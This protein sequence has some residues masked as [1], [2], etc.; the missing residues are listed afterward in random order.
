MPGP[1]ADPRTRNAIE[2]K[3]AE[4]HRGW[5]LGVLS[6]LALLFLILAFRSAWLC[7]DAY[8]TFRTIDNFLGGYGLRWNVAERVQ[9]FSHPLWMLLLSAISFITG[10]IYFTALGLSLALSAGAIAVFLLYIAP[11]FRAAGLGLVIFCASKAFID[12]STS[13]LENPLTHFLLALHFA[14]LL[15]M[16]AGSRSLLLLSLTAA[17]GILN[18][19]DTLLF[20]APGVV[21][22][23]WRVRSWRS[24]GVVA[25]GA[26]PF[27]L[28]ELFSLVYYGFLFP[29]TAYAKLGNGFSAAQLL[30]QG[31]YYLKVSLLKDPVTIAAIAA[32]LAGGIA[33]AIKTKKEAP[34]AIAA[35]AAL[36]LIY[37]LKIGGDFMAGRFF[38]GVL[39]AAVAAGTQLPAID[40]KRMWIPALATAIVLGLI[41]S[42]PPL[43]S[44]RNYRLEE[45]AH[46]M[47][48]L[49][50][51][52]DERG[53][54]YRDTGL[55]RVL[56]GEADPNK[57]PWT[58]RGDYA[59]ESGARAAILPNIGI[60]AYA[61]GPEV[62]AVD[63][64]ALADPLLARLPAVQSRGLYIGHF[65][66]RFPDG[67]LRSLTLGRNDLLD[68]DLAAYYDRLTLVTRGR[69]F[70]RG[71]WASIFYLNFVHRT[72]P[73]EE[74]IY[75]Y[76]SNDYLEPP[77]Y[78][79]RAEDIAQ[80]RKLEGEASRF[81]QVRFFHESYGARV[82]FD[83]PARASGVE[84]TLSPGRSYTIAF[85]LGEKLVGRADVSLKGAGGEGALSIATIPTPEGVRESG[86]DSIWIST[87]SPDD[88]HGRMAHL[89]LVP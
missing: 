5:H 50:R 2:S 3:S 17:L 35:G 81:A 27:L 52:T 34:I 62:Y 41:G 43:L 12:Y 53:F 71:R 7:D 72:A 87:A 22:G 61:A 63:P 59:R 73:V 51:V 9:S 84:T 1:M 40:S 16:P 77:A 45:T 4:K 14:L 28:W 23:F 47:I 48:D 69:L 46:E 58:Y 74:S 31:F 64:L 6:G 24:L 54:Y 44:G 10:E 42:H 68:P 26:V 65:G 75:K 55:L 80:P 67:Y 89:Q 33:A 38:S 86:F 79:L 19:M 37:I 15:R 30:E 13:G 70:Q 78:H 36:Y 18:R 39:L 60:A 82:Y 21:V 32:G 29:N 83:E 49:R 85:F 57:H 88:G 66:R 8:I 56:A 20:F 76:P 25:L 11:S